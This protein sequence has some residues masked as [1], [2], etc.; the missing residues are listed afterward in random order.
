[1]MTLA[2]VVEQNVLVD[3]AIVFD[4]QVVAE[5]K[6]NAVKDLD[7]VAAMFEYVAG[8]HGAHLV[9]QPV[10]QADRR[11]VV[12]HPEPDQRLAFAILRGI[13]VAVGFGFQRG[14]ARIKRVDERFA[15]ASGSS[16]IGRRIRT[17]QIKLVQ[18][19]A[20]DIAAM[21]RVAIRELA[22]ESS[23]HRRETPFPRPERL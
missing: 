15:S 8:Q 21:L 16:R 13:G 4:R 14:V 20:D 9:S 18:F 3:G 23:I 17:S 6:L 12:H 2:A 7:V 5:G 19:L 11:A 22:I 1:M 10:I